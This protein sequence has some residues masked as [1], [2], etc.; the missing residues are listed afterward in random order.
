MTE[1]EHVTTTSHFE[2]KTTETSA[3][4]TPKTTKA[5]TVSGAFS[6]HSRNCH[7]EDTSSASKRLS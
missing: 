2:S 4:Q 7:K 3:K 6:H 1:R 5:C